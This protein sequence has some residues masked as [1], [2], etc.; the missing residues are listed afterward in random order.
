MRNNPAKTNANNFAETS[1]KNPGARAAP[2]GI[3]KQKAAQE[4]VKRSE[5]ISKT[6]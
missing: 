4:P 1:A 3:S 2:N 6:Q 5:R